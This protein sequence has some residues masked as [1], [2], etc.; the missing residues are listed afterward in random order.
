LFLDVL[1]KIG[2]LFSD[3]ESDFTCFGKGFGK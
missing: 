1:L 3:A 2:Y